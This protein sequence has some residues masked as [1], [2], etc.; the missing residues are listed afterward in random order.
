MTTISKRLEKLEEAGGSNKVHVV[1]MPDGLTRAE[2][3][4]WEADIGSPAYRT[5]NGIHSKT[6]VV[7][8]RSFD[9]RE[10]SNVPM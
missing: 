5:A 4:A 2:Q 1:R 3:A 7:I 8:L 6:L 10:E 9:I